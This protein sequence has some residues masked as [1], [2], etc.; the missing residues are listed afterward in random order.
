MKSMK[1]KISMVS[2]EL[3]EVHLAYSLDFHMLDLL[4][5]YWIASSGPTIK[6][7]MI[8]KQNNAIE[9]AFLKQQSILLTL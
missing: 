6:S 3:L 8:F 1:S 4:E 9:F 2:L 5:T 7:S